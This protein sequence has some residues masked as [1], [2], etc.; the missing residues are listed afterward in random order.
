MAFFRLRWLLGA[1]FLFIH[2]CGPASN[3]TDNGQLEIFV[4]NQ[5]VTLLPE[6][7]ADVQVRLHTSAPLLSSAEISLRSSNDMPLPDSIRFS[8]DTTTLYPSPNQDATTTLHLGISTPLDMDS[9]S[10]RIYAHSKD[11]TA[12]RDLTLS[13]PKSASSW[14]RPVQ[15]DGTDQV[16]AL[17]GDH[18]GGVYVAAATTAA[19]ANLSSQGNFDAYLLHY[20]ANG[21]V[22]FVTPLAT[23]G[24]DVITAL[25]VDADD[26]VYAAGYTYGAFLGQQNVG[27]ADG[28][29]AKIGKDGG[30]AWLQQIGSTENDQL[31]SIALGPDGGIYVAGLT[32]GSL[33]GHNNAGGSDVVVAKLSST[34][35]LD[36]LNLF[37]TVENE[38]TNGVSDY[39]TVG[40]A[41]DAGGA[42]YVC[43]STMGTFPLATAQGRGD[44]F[45][46]RLQEGGQI[47]WL[48]QMGSSNNDALVAMVPH[49][50]ELIYAVGWAQGSFF[51]QLPMGNQDAILLAVKPDGTVASVRQFGTPYSDVLNALSI[52]NDQIYVAGSTH[53]AFPGQKSSGLQDVFFARLSL[54]GSTQWLRQLGT[55]QPD[56]GSAITVSKQSLYLGGTTFGDFI[57]GAKLMG[58]DG[59]LN[60]YPL[61]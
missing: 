7:T 17:A 19:F 29:V 11:N 44:A 34:G 8:F 25:A 32:E 16:L 6:Q 51:G 10:V 38:R 26:T 33:F 50:S 20:R 48:N 3:G 46:A 27:K 41:V 47:M 36:W 39:D 58:S 18:S 21:A 13:S 57:T 24:T 54:E 59:L 28:F 5:T 49:P 53:G 9:Y 52:Q 56:S 45:I 15:T 55:S 23:T 14:R 22:S 60:Q 37:G 43:G 1:A 61:N 40:L 30:L 4:N 31:T 35:H 42:I 2:A 12:Q